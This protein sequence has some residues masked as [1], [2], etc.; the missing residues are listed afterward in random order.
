MLERLLLVMRNLYINREEGFVG[1]GLKRSESEYVADCSDIDDIIVFRADGKMMVSKVSSKAFF[2]KNIIHAQVWKKGDK[3]TVYN[4][5]YKDGKSG[6]TRMKRFFVNSITRDKEYDLTRGTEGSKVEYFSANPNGEAEVLTVLLRH[7]QRLKK[8]KFDID[9]AELDIKGRGAGGN[10]VTKHPVKRI[11]LKEKGISTLGARKIWYDETVRRLNGDGRGTLLGEFMPDDKIL[12][13]L[14]DGSYKLIGFDLS[15]HF[16]ED[17]IHLEK[18]VPEK[19]MSVVYYDGA[20]ESWFVK[21]FMVEGSTKKVLFISESEGS[22]LGMAT[23]NHYPIAEVR[24]N[25]KFKKT[26]DKGNELVDLVEFIAV[27]GL[28][29]IGNKLSNLPITEVN[30]ATPDLEKE[31]Q[32]DEE[33]KQRISE[34]LSKNK[35]EDS[36]KDTE[37]IEDSEEANEVKPEEVEL[38]ISNESEKKKEDKKQDASSVDLE[39]TNTNDEGQLDLF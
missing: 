28:K 32:A 17:M 8:L 39:I 5:V 4:M 13:I 1:T 33:L 2:G 38:E 24:F 12:V 21:R 16:D 35:I 37:E 31:M 36:E 20:K 29:A 11:E 6:P 18:F 27:K 23:T 9:L 22:K 34:T 10:L 26:R 30:L 3:R 7:N 14:G 25:K 15:T 19:P